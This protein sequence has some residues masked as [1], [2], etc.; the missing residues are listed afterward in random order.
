MFMSSAECQLLF[1]RSHI[2]DLMLNDLELGL[3]LCPKITT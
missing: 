1:T 2:K 3:Q